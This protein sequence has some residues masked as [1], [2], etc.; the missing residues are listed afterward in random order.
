MSKNMKILVINSGSSSI[1]FQLIG[2]PGDDVIASGGV[3]RIGLE[4]SRI[5]YVTSKVK[6]EE[7]AEIS[8]H[9]EGL[10]MIAGLLLDQNHGVI[11][12]YSGIDAVGHRVVHGGSSFSETYL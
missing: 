1:K 3:E 5:K 9:E 11:T 6:I 7:E 12:D 8:N 2:M 10:Q 4:G